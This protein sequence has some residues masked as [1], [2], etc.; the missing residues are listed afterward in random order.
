MYRNILVVLRSFI[1]YVNYGID[2]TAVVVFL[3]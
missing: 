3:F 2:T 1:E